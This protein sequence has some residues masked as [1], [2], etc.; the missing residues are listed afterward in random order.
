MIA[1]I[2]PFSKS[3]FK[4]SPYF[5]GHFNARNIFKALINGIQRIT[6]PLAKAIFTL[7]LPPP[8]INPKTKMKIIGKSN[9]EDHSRRGF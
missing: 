1:V 4:R 3:S 7:T 5:I 6:E 2:R 8:P 9:A